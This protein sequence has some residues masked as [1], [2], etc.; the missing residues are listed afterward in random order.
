LVSEEKKARID[1]TLPLMLTRSAFVPGQ[2]I[3]WMV[4]YRSQLNLVEQATRGG[5]GIAQSLAISNGSDK[6]DYGPADV[7]VELR[8]ESFDALP[9]GTARFELR[10]GRRFRVHAKRSL[11]SGVP[12][13]D[14]EWL[15]PIDL[16]RVPVGPAHEFIQ[17]LVAQHFEE[18]SA[19]KNYPE[20]GTP[21]TIDDARWVGW[22]A[23]S[24]LHGNR[25]D[26]I[27]M[28]LQE[29]DPLIRLDAIFSWFARDVLGPD[30]PFTEPF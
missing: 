12:V 23:A 14:V 18:P 9:N 1:D 15:D 29:D 5:T 16:P 13:V 7:G 2:F 27:L 11:P 24:A 3:E 6:T 20:W 17:A 4:E 21:D 8:V 19:A 26:R 10:A 30:S 25:P 28:L 22:R